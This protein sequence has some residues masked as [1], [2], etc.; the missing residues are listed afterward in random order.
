MKLKLLVSLVLFTAATVFA[1]KQQPNIIMIAVDDLNDWI[2]VYGGNPQVITP[3]M[4]KLAQKAMVFR[5]AVHDL[6]L[7]NK[8]TYASRQRFFITDEK[9]ELHQNMLFGFRKTDI[10]EAVI[11]GKLPDTI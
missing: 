4:N 2:G 5:N 8:N 6:F 9:F 3:N 10:D 11:I 7:W 1:Q